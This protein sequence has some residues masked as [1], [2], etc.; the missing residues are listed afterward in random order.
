MEAKNELDIEL[1]DR[2]PQILP[3]QTTGYQFL[4][5]FAIE[6]QPADLASMEIKNVSEKKAYLE[7]TPNKPIAKMQ[8][9]I[10]IKNTFLPP[11]LSAR[12]PVV[13]FPIKVPAVPQPRIEPHIALFK[14]I[15]GSSKSWGLATMIVVLKKLSTE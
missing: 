12:K 3:R 4:I 15:V 11:N 2:I 14:L 9:P 6:G 5:R 1:D 8:I 7:T 13:S 10:D